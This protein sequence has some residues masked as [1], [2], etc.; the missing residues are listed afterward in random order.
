MSSTPWALFSC[1]RPNRSRPS[2]TP[3][4]S[5]EG[6]RSLTSCPTPA[7]RSSQSRRIAPNGS[8]AFMRDEVRHAEKVLA[9]AAARERSRIVPGQVRPERLQ[10]SCRIGRAGRS[11]GDVDAESDHDG[12]GP[13]RAEA[14][15]LRAEGRRPWRRR[16]AGRW[17]I[18]GRGAAPRFPSPPPPPRA[19]QALRRNRV[20]VLR[21]SRT[22][23]SE[24]GWHRGCPGATTIAAHGAPCPPAA[25]PR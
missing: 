14:C 6:N 25:R 19:G 21:R 24:G 4:F 15:A 17:A 22:G 13:V 8:D 20:G 5:P 10:R 3:F 12:Q 7:A 11:E 9:K 1:R 16:A 2:N 23:R 18:S